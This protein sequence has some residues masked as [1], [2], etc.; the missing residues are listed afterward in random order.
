MDTPMVQAIQNAGKTSWR[1]CLSVAQMET[2]ELSDDA[3]LQE[4]AQRTRYLATSVPHLTARTQPAPSR[5]IL[6]DSLHTDCLIAVPCAWLSLFE[7]LPS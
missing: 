6:E 2:H 5:S 7:S 4:G 1:L 3:P